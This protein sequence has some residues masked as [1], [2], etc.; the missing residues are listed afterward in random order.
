MG[1]IEFLKRTGYALVASSLILLMFLSLAQFGRRLPVLYSYAV[2]L[3]GIA[4]VL[5]AKCLQSIQ[6]Y[7]LAKLHAYCSRCGWYGSGR[8]W[9]R[10]EC[11]P[12]CDAEEVLVG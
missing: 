11:C 1:A 4:L 5:I 12:E 2:F 10:S 7:R 8:D 6:Y 3:V 9:H